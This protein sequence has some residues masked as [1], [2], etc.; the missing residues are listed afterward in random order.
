[1]MIRDQMKKEKTSREKILEFAEH[2][3]IEILFKSDLEV[4]RDNILLKWH[5][6]EWTRYSIK[7]IPTLIDDNQAIKLDSR[8][9]STIYDSPSLSIGESLE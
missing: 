2:E 4:G 6:K 3:G 7:I 8:L 5:G 1:M 9:T